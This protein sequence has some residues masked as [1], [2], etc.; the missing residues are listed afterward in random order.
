MRFISSVTLADKLKI[1]YL[2][3]HL[4]GIGNYWFDVITKLSTRSAKVHFVDAV[5]ELKTSA[6]L[7]PLSPPNNNKKK[8]HQSRLYGAHSSEHLCNN[9]FVF[10]RAVTYDQGVWCDKVALAVTGMTRML[11]TLHP[12]WKESLSGL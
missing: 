1:L 6:W 7:L 2:I 5:L 12:D 10:S 4:L 9:Y 3:L 8:K 11:F